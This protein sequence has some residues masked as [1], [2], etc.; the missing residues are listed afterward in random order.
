MKILL[1]NNYDSFAKLIYYYFICLQANIDILPFNKLNITSLKKYDAF[2]ISPGPGT[3]INYKIIFD[4][5]NIFLKKKY[6]LGVCLGMQ[7][8]GTYLG[9]N[10][11]KLKTPTHG[12]KRKIKVL[13]PFD[14][15]F[16]SF[17]K[18]FNVALYNSW[19]FHY[20]TFF[21]LNNNI[22]ISSLDKHNLIMSF[23]S[24]EL[25]INAIQFHPESILSFNGIKLYS[26]WLNL[27]KNS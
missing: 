18:S 6:F 15:L 21:N 25:K 10:L 20:N 26:N 23:Y 22:F 9:Y 17:P 16:I 8:I 5:L 1:I 7:I 24:N 2:I 3:A 13:D 19:A 14:P 27:I 12:I 11:V 4:I